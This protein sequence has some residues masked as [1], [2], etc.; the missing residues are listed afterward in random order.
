MASIST[1]E[2][3]R[4]RAALISLITS[5]DKLRWAEFRDQLSGGETLPSELLESQRNFD[6]TM[7]EQ[8]YD[9][10]EEWQARSNGASFYCYLD[11]GYPDQLRTV[12]DF[13]PFVFI[14]GDEDPLKSGNEDLGI[15]IVGSRRPSAESVALTR[16]ITSQLVSEGI[17]AIAGLAEGIDQEVHRTA[18]KHDARTVG[19]IGTGI[20]RYY[21]ASSRG[22][23][24]RMEQGDGMV[25]SQFV[26]GSPPTRYSFPMRNATM[27]AYGQASIIVEASEKSG[28]RHQA[29][30]AVRHG[31][32]LILLE[33]VARGTTWGHEL[34]AEG[35]LID[36]YIARDAE[37][38]VELAF[39]VFDR[40]TV[41]GV[42]EIK[43]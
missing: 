28:T 35:A 34:T 6:P 24:E 33:Q 9:R 37:E 38:A 17:T 15:C 42:M 18:L 3:S 1:S 36:A 26:P 7:F 10:I 25:L 21:P 31:R 40:R 19:V 43:R 20:D 13:P 2:L 5:G 29:R 11:D 16:Q 41:P 23:Q 32:P 14:K 12:W 4:E 22:I 30:Q 39:G 8:G 27:S